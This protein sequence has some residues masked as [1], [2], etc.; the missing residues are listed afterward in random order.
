MFY[1]LSPN[2]FRL[3]VFANLFARFGLYNPCAYW[4]GKKNGW[5]RLV[6]V[7]RW[8]FLHFFGLFCFL[9]IFIIVIVFLLVLLVISG[10]LA[11][12]LF[13]LFRLLDFAQ[14]LPFLGKSVS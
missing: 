10:F 13:F 3:M 6:R 8:V 11:V 9:L 12:I 14:I 4:N 1:R 7:N 5:P 2:D